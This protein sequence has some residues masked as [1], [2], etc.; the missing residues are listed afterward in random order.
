MR[1]DIG[2][3]DPRQ[4]D[5]PGRLQALPAG[6]S[7]DITAARGV[8]CPMKR[9]MTGPVRKSVGGRFLDDVIAGVYP[10]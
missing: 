8:P 5:F 9:S 2:S 3:G 6:A 1:P 4:H 7:P 10:R